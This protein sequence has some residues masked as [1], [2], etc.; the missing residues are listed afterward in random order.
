MLEAFN[1]PIATL[2][3]GLNAIVDDDAKA[4][5]LKDMAFKIEIEN[6]LAVI[7]TT[8]IFSNEDLRS[9]EAILTFPV[10]FDAVLTALNAEIDGRKLVA[11]A[12]L[13]DD[14]REDYEEAVSKGKMAILHEEPL[15]GLH[16][17]SIG[18]LGPGKTVHVE[19]EMVMP[20]AT[21]GSN[22]YLRLPLVVGEIYG[23]SPF[24]PT[25]DLVSKAGLNLSATLTVSA[26]GGRVQ[27]ADGGMVKNGQ[28]IK[29]DRNLF[30]QFPDQFF[31]QCN[32]IDA[33][34]RGVKISL[35]APRQLERQLDIAVLVDHS[36]STGD[37][38]GEGN[39]HQ[40]I[41]KGLIKWS[42]FLRAE[43]KIAL[44]EFDY[45]AD[46]IGTATGSNF[47]QMVR[48]L[49]PPNGSTELGR[50]VDAVMR[51]GKKPILVLTDGQTYSNEIA[52]AQAEGCPI[53]AILV[54]EGSLDAMIGHLAAQTGGQVIAAINDDVAGALNS[55][56]PVLR[57]GYSLSKGRISNGRPDMV[58]T[59]RGGIAI[60]IAWSGHSAEASSD[61]KGRYAASLILSSAEEN[62]AGQIAIAHGLT[63]HLTS[64]IIIDEVGEKVEGLPRMVKVP[65]DAGMYNYSHMPELKNI[66]LE[67]F[68]FSHDDLET[69]NIH[70]PFTGS[71]RNETE[72]HSDE[73]WSLVPS[74]RISQQDELPTMLA[75][76]IRLLMVEK[77]IISLAQLLGMNV[78]AV[79][80]LIVAFHDQKID[81]NAGRFIRSCKNFVAQQNL[82]SIELKAKEFIQ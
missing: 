5:P 69:K 77:D 29:L 19:T 35:A 43:D 67:N 4:L 70:Y 38:L 62:I 41:Q 57:K 78:Y 42:E 60:D 20:L 66:V 45:N 79:A 68:E 52:Q 47:E 12:K 21:N 32:G 63:S 64:L 75:A 22:L 46:F 53:H 82:T 61:A 56:L 28:T 11:H 50:A 48:K 55:M 37:R 72:R 80:L 15:R 74:H 26:Q 59:M 34:G 25:D 58:T 13:K 7:R 76:R 23:V 10:P 40:A 33:W 3:E 8:R 65:V 30:L 16:M 31:G 44:W 54:G 9:I 14:A 27:F 24:L 1:Y 39:V 18:Q 81:R 73:D 49:S 2:R 6:G 51:Q 17:L 71:S 36:G